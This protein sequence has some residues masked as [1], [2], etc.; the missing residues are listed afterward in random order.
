MQP[1][2]QVQQALQ[3]QPLATAPQQG[4]PDAKN[5][6]FVGGLGV[7]RPACYPWEAVDQ[8]TTLMK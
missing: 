1:V 8:N 5:T 7:Q 2:L 4:T 3:A 6:V